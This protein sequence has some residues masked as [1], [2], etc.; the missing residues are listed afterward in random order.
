MVRKYNSF[1]AESEWYSCRNQWFFGLG[2]GIRKAVLG[3]AANTAILSAV[4]VVV[5]C[6]NVGNLLLARAQA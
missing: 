4:L 5:A 3:I 6:A 2:A 1:A